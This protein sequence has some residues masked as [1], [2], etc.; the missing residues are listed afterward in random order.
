MVFLGSPDYKTTGV[1]RGSVVRSQTTMNATKTNPRDVLC[2]NCHS[3]QLEQTQKQRDSIAWWI[4]FKCQQCGAT[5]DVEN[6]NS[7]VSK[8]HGDVTTPRRV[9]LEREAAYAR[10]RGESA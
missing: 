5:G 2:A 9:D 1:S 3:A 8:Y 10:T 7:G 4:T 6:R